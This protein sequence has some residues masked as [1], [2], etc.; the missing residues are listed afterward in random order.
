VERAA[1]IIVG[2]GVVGSACAYFLAQTGAIPAKHILIIEKD[3]SY[4]FASTAR[5]VGGLRQQ[6]STPENIALSQFTLS[7]VR[8][9][10][11][12]F[13]CDADVAFREQGYLITASDDGCAILANN[14]ILQRS[15]G[16][17]IVLLDRDALARRFPW[18]NTNGIAAGSFGQS[19]E[20]WLDPVSLMT[21]FRKAAQAK[22]VLVMADEVV[23]IDSTGTQVCAVRLASG[24][25]ITCGTLINAAG[26]S[27]GKV[28]ALASLR[29]PVEPRKR[30]VYVID[31]RK[32]PAALHEGPLTVDPSG[33]WFRPE[34]RVFLCG[35]SPKEDQEPP[36]QNLDE[37]DYGLFEREVWPLLAMRVPPFEEIKAI[38][39]WAGFY[40]Y[41]SVDQNAVIGPHPEL[42]NFY[43]ANGFSGHGLQQAAGAGRAVAELI[44]YNKFQ[45]L[46]LTRFGYAR[47]AANAPLFESNVI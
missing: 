36:P 37:I 46:D 21:L 25:R 34:G 15:M 16:A 40:D 26:P 3:P 8:N 11:T 6:F 31:C 29:L 13:D 24:G 39:A 5:S 14:V 9:L 23:A 38:N 28:A 43:F 10:R 30:Y 45:T 33:V 18:L 1:V 12:L 35:V 17:D 4:A 2:G 27:A 22:G 41:N 20:G 7:L 42:A 47:I 44:V 19:G 32:A